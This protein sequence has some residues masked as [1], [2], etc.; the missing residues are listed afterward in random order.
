MILRKFDYIVIPE[1]QGNIEED[2]RSLLVAN[3]RP[4]TLKH[5][6]DVA[7]M[8]AR[9]ADMHGLDRRKCIQA[10]LMHDIS[11][12][13]RAD[14]MLSHAREMGMTLCEAEE[15]FPFLLHQRMSA[16]V[17]R[18]HFDISDEKILSPVACH[19]TLNA[20][21]DEYDM[22]LFIADKLAWD[23]E[24]TP[25]FYDEVYSLL[26]DLP[27]ACLA[28]MNYM[29]DSGKLLCPH[30]NWKLAYAALTRR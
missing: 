29:Q 14:D 4:K 19:T 18:E 15:K 27:A 16:I 6:L 1:I 12:V 17:A 22:A 23:Q 8:N 5:I 26:H 3:G 2:V 30:T 11:A 7:D 10:A 24:G 28:Y 9:I 25:P 20:A 21:P 13:I